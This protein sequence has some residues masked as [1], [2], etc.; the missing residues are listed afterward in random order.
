MK[1]LILPF[2]IFSLFAEEAPLKD[3]S[4]K[5]PTKDK[6]VVSNLKKREVEKS[7]QDNEKLKK[8]KNKPTSA[9]Q[10]VCIDEMVQGLGPK[11]LEAIAKDLGESAFRVEGGARSESIKNFM[12]QRISK[13]IYGEKKDTNSANPPKVVDHDIYREIY[14]SQLGK[15]MLLDINTYCLENIGF[16]KP[17]TM[18]SI[19]ATGSFGK[20]TVSDLGDASNVIGASKQVSSFIK[21]INEYTL[22]DENRNTTTDFYRSSKTLNLLKR[23]SIKIYEKDEDLGRKLGSFCR[24]Q[25]IPAMCLRYKCNTTKNLILDEDLKCK[26]LLVSYTKNPNDQN[27]KIACALTA[28]LE[29][30]KKTFVELEK[31]KDFSKSQEQS[32]SFSQASDIVKSEYEKIDEITSVGSKELVNEVEALKNVDENVQEI[33]DKCSSDADLESE[34]CKDLITSLSA[35]NEGDIL[36]ENELANAVY[37]QRLLNAGNVGK[38]E[39]KEFLEKNNL[40][41]K[42]G[43]QLDS[44]DPSKLAQ[45]IANDYKTKKNALKDTMMDKLNAL[46]D[47]NGTKKAKDFQ[48]K[49]TIK[50]KEESLKNEK[51]YIDTMFEYNNIITSYLTLSKQ[52]EGGKDSAREVVGSFGQNKNSEMASLEKYKANLT[53]EQQAEYDQYKEMFKN[54]SSGSSNRKNSMDSVDF[55][56]FLD[57]VLGTPKKKT[58][59]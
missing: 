30:Y 10:T 35:Q 49:G 18:L 31:Q 52:G 27:G 42:Y 17:L 47:T 36:V 19:D 43:D 12:K 54:E 9:L 58:K 15:N 38:D 5:D 14:K 1:L 34:F 39:L 55:I 51:D 23:A 21:K 16:D 33:Q 57:D 50:L 40:L 28:K 6:V 22:G 44:L 56:G 59:P 3:K 32:A 46:R 37:E 24:R 20:A 45:I 29:S 26:D 11:E 48:A 2:L 25:M 7:L 4:E 13:L 41:D 8:C 53:T